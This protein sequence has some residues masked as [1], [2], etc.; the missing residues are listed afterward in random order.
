VGVKIK[1]ASNL[2]EAAHQLE[3]FILLSEIEIIAL[4]GRLFVIT[5]FIIFAVLALGEL[6]KGMIRLHRRSDLFFNVA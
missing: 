6:I 1:R 4:V 2:K 5:F 3:A